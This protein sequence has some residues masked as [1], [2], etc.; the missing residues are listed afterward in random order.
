MFQHFLKPIKKFRKTYL[1]G[2]V[3]GSADDDPSAISTY[4]VV[5]ATT[6]FSQ[7]WLLLVSTPLVIAI[8]NMSAKIGDVTKK[9]LIRLIKDN[10]GRSP[11]IVCVIA[12]VVANLLTLLADIVGMAAGFQLITGESYVFFIIPLII[13]VWYIVVFDSYKKIARY[14]FW[15]SGILIAYIIAGIMARPDWFLILKSFF[16]PKISFNLSYI[17]AGLALLGTTFSPYAFFWQTEEEIEEN[18]NSSPK[19][20]RQT[21]RSVSFGFIYSNLIAF[22]IIVASASA[23]LN[24]NINFLTIKDI[25]N[26]LTPFTG[27]WATTL[28]GIGLIGSG[29]L[30]IPILASSSAYAIAELLKWPCGLDKKPSRAKGFYGIISFGFILCIA[31]L[32]FNLHPIKIMFFSQVIVGILT[33]LVIYFILRIAGSKKIMGEWRSHW[34]SL[35]AGWLTIALILSGSIFF[36]CYLF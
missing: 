1:P 8:Q 11:A 14:F 31:A 24:N 6:G 30:A 29:M 33:S 27:S 16:A 19:Q 25:A 4:S 22:F 18:H 13:F 10:F 26:A 32:I 9:G 36:I 12:L 17:F 34:L 35:L 28:F 23:A 3:T 20:I 7:L 21:N 2:I 15:F 5:G